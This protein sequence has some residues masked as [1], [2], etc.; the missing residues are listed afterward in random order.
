MNE[1]EMSGKK[2]K[3]RPGEEE[4]SPVNKTRQRQTPFSCPP[5]LVVLSGFFTWKDFGYLN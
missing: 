5:G 4:D 3:C 2:P 1:P